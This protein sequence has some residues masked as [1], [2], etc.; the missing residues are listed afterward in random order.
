LQGLFGQFGTVVEATVISDKFTGRSK[1]FGFVTL[2]E[3]EAA[4]KAIEALHN[5]DLSGR[6]MV[7][8][9]ARPKEESTGYKRP[10]E[11]RGGDRRSYG[12][13]NGGS[14]GDRKPYNRDDNSY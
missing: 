13:G 3:D 5:S 9:V 10:Y 8:N 7:V 1:G 14:Y 6:P 2:E 4:Q 11:N 12:G